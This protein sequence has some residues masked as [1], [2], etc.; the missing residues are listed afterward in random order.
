MTSGESIA[1]FLGLH[2]VGVVGVSRSGKEFGAVVFRDLAKRGYTVVPVNRQGGS[3]DG[4]PCVRS[5]NELAGSVDGIVVVV[6]PVEALAVVEQ[7]FSSGINDVWMQQGAESPAA[8]QF[9]RDHHMNEVHGECLL[10]FLARH[11]FPHSWHRAI[12]K[13]TGRL[14]RVAVTG[15]Q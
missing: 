3:I 2:R 14:P 5:V 9:C 4:I 6:P 1:R 15:Q 12:R 10:M 13:L 11:E 8:I 7:A